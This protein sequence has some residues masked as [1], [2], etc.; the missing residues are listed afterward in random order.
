MDGIALLRV[1]ANQR[2]YDGGASSPVKTIKKDGSG[3]GVE[4]DAMCVLGFAGRG[5]WWAALV[6]GIA[7]GFDVVRVDKDGKVKGGKGGGAF[8]GKGRAMGRGL[9]SYQLFKAALDFLGM[10]VFSPCPTSQTADGGA[11]PNFGSILTGLVCVLQQG[12]MSRRRWC[13]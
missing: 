10:F 7:S 13:S 2:G 3:T 4:N 1:W 11:F 8:G 12:G 5:A 6:Q 9:S